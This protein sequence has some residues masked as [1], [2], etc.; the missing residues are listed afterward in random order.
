MK[1]YLTMFLATSLVL[2]LCAC[3]ISVKTD[4]DVKVD[5]DL[6]TENIEEKDALEV[7]KD[8]LDVTVTIPAEI[9]D[10]E[11]TQAD[12]DAIAL[13]KGYTSV[14][15][16]ED[17]SVTYVMSGFEHAK[18]MEEIDESLQKLLDETVASEDNKI[19]AIVHNDNYTDFKVNV[20]G[21]SLGF[22]DSLNSIAF[23]LYGAMYN[24]FN[25]TPVENI[26]IEYISNVTGKV[27]SETNSADLAE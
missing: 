22:V 5:V 16:N 26:H 15:L 21:E 18:M 11:L 12:Y 27:I 1:K 13:E 2:S 8:S 6:D 23:M 14:T 17:G 10:K 24:A 9:V 7:V 25:G 4:N 3:A 19:T 20:D